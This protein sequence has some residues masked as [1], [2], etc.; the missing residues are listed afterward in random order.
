MGKWKTIEYP[1]A[2]Y[3]VTSTIV[4]F[5]PVFDQRIYIDIILKNLDFYRD[6]HNFKLYAF[7]VMPDHL[8]FILHPAHETKIKEIM[9]DFKSYTS[10]KLTSQLKENGRF[11]ILNH[12]RKFAT[13]KIE[14]PFWTEGNR[15]IGI[16]TEKVLRSKMDYIHTNP[17][18]RG[19]VT[20][21]EDYPYS[22]FRNYYLND[23]SIIKVDRDWI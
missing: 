10:K 9:R 18:R 7:V 1:G 5:V 23:D 8:H 19:L 2:A 12:L 17:L 22:S 6:K 3:F 16:Y 11:E 20:N 15:P 4:N 13:P 14:N 21:L